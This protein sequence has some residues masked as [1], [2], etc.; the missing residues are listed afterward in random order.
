MK[1]SII[2]ITKNS[3][4]T[5]SKTIESV[6][7]Q[8]YKDYEHIFI[9]G[10]SND[11]TIEI[12][13]TYE[14]RHPSNVKIFQQTPRGISYAMNEGIRKANGE[15]ML[16][17]HADDAL[18]D[19]QVLAD[20]ANFLEGNA[21]DWVYGKIMVI[22]AAGKEIGVF[23]NKKIFQA[24]SEDTFKSWLL[25]LYNYIPHQAVFIKKNCFEKF[26]Y[27]DESISSAMD[28]DMWLR[29]RTKTTWAYI[30]RCISTF[31]LSETT[32]TGS[33]EKKLENWNN[34][35][36]V[37][38]KSLKGITYALARLIAHVVRSKQC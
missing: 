16:H 37:Q 33:A 27:F 19:A 20:V 5:L 22:D 4:T 11:Q 28:P 26:G 36:H 21:Y 30:D 10:N 35:K 24:N 32:Q 14:A 12:L 7:T 38:K 31:T 3:A 18:Y 9:D 13:K 15:Y 2:T 8:S 17:L 1:F 23:P 25:Q 34:V 29:I 6:E